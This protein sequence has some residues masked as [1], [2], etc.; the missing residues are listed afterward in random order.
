MSNR[1]YRDQADVFKYLPANTKHFN[2]KGRDIWCYRKNTE[3][4][5]EFEIALF[6]DPDE[7]GYCAQ[8]ISPT[9]EAKWKRDV[10]CIYADGAISVGGMQGQSR[11]R[12]TLLEV[13][14][15]SSLWAEG[16][17][18]MLAA[19][20]FPQEDPQRLETLLPF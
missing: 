16:V 14:G 19:E 10:V 5:I 17:A 20:Q 1:I 6:F 12:S 3:V 4:G 2:N 18:I 11:T 13:Y 7:N 9:L 15:R 8:L